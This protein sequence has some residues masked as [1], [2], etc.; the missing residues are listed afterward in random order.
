[1]V[2]DV[3]WK[4]VV[5]GHSAKGRHHEAKLKLLEGLIVIVNVEW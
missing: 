1:M 2:D 5:K 4:K 3:D